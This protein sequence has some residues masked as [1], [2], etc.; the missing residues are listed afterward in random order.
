MRKGKVRKIKGRRQTKKKDEKKKKQRLFF[1]FLDF[2]VFTTF[3]ILEEEVYFLFLFFCFI[4]KIFLS[5]L[6]LIQEKEF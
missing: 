3:K 4:L 2:L 5:L 6:F 1:S